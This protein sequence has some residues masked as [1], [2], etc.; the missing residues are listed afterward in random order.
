[1]ATTT[2]RLT[3]RVLLS[4]PPPPAA[5]QH[6]LGVRQLSAPPGKP[7]LR[8]T[9]GCRPSLSVGD[10]RPGS[11]TRQ[12]LGAPPPQPPGGAA[13]ATAGPADPQQPCYRFGP[14]RFSVIP[15]SAEGKVSVR[16]VP[17]QDADTL[18]QRLRRV[19]RGGSKAGKAGRRGL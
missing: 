7:R 5:P 19:P 18:V 2:R 6:A 1:M 10:M 14:T 13:A 4:A 16:F 15:K 11:S 9:R 17:N 3:A 8:V 12:A